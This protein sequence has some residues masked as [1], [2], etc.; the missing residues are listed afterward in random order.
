MNRQFFARSSVYAPQIDGPAQAYASLCG[1]R[2][3]RH[4]SASSFENREGGDPRQRV[5]RSSLGDR[6]ETTVADG[7]LGR[8]ADGE[9]SSGFELTSSSHRLRANDFGRGESCT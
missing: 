5:D 4:V 3:R 9:K 7:G 8:V 6:A 1:H 2:H